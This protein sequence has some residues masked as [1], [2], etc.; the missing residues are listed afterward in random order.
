MRGLVSVERVVDHNVNIRI[1]SDVVG[2]LD[3]P[4]PR[5]R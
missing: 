2:A 5:C 3:L 1:K 4:T